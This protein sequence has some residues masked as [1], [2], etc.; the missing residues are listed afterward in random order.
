MFRVTTQDDDF[1]LRNPR[2]AYSRILGGLGPRALAWIPAPRAST[3]SQETPHFRTPHNPGHTGLRPDMTEGPTRQPFFPSASGRKP[4]LG[5]REGKQRPPRAEAQPTARAAGEERGAWDVLRPR[6]A[7]AAPGRDGR[8]GQGAA[9]ARPSRQGRVGLVR[10]LSFARTLV[11]TSVST[12]VLLRPD[13]GRLEATR[14]G[15]AVHAG[16]GAGWGWGW[17]GGVTRAQPSCQRGLGSGWQ[18]LFP[19]GCETALPWAH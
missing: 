13:R 18:R 3:G 14:H 17:G 6:P 2:P 1:H 16:R 15:A 5:R 9:H 10:A 19:V 11:L 7:R 12:S 4:G 8:W